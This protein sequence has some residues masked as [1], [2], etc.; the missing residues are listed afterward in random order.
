MSLAQQLNP[1]G[2]VNPGVTVTVQLPAVPLTNLPAVAPPT[3]EDREHP[4]TLTV[5][6]TILFNTI[7]VPPEPP[8]HDTPDVVC[9]YNL[10]TVQVDGLDD[11][12]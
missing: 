12:K 11:T 10:E 7:Q 5:P 6:D 4:D 2:A 3:A 1:F 9:T 8:T